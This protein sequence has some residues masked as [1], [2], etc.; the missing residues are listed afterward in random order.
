SSVR[1]AETHWHMVFVREHGKFHPLIVGPLVTS[2][3]ASWGEGG[4][5][6]WIKFKLGVF[7]PNLPLRNFLDL[8]T[9][10]PEGA[11]KSFWLS[12]SVWQLPNYENV[13]TFVTRLI[14]DETLV[15]DPIVEAALRVNRRTSP[16][17]P[18]GIAS[19]AQPG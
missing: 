9:P 3:E 10:M 14:H 17:V 1:P 8:E 2:G 7:M 16:R 4:E 11:G 13:D 18:C 12:G 5:I 6:L 19:F 15:C